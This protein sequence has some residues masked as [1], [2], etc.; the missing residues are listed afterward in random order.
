MDE[1]EVMNK[2]ENENEDSSLKMWK[3]VILGK[4]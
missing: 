3:K 2:D 1:N 4:S